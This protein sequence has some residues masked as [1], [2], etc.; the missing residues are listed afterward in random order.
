MRNHKT[1][2][3]VY[4]CK[5]CKGIMQWL[6]SAPTTLYNKPTDINDMYNFLD[7]KV[8]KIRLEH[9]HCISKGRTVQ[10]LIF[11]TEEESQ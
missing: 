2:I 9:C 7:S 8:P 3:A 5:K 1:F 4:Q 6:C 11:I 10:E